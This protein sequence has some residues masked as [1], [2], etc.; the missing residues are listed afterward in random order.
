MIAAIDSGDWKVFTQDEL[1]P[2]AWAGFGETL[3]IF[4]NSL[5]R[6][7]GGLIMAYRVVTPDGRRRIATCRLREDWSV[8]SGS[9]QPFSDDLTY[10]DQNEADPASGSWV[11]DP[12]FVTLQGRLYLH[13]NF[14][15][16]PRPNRIYLVEVDPVTLT[17]VS[18]AR[19][20]V[21]TGSRQEIEKNWIFFEHGEAVYVVYNFAPLVILHADL[22]D[23]NRVRCTPAFRHEWDAACYEGAYGQIRGGATPVDVNGRFH[24]ICHSA[25]RTDPGSNAGAEPEDICYVA[26]LVVLDGTPPFAPFLHSSRPV[27]E[28]T[29]RE[30]AMPFQPRL[31]PRCCEAVYPVGAVADGADLIVSYGLNNRYAVLRRMPRSE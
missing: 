24:F 15:S 16:N 12:R 27:L 28:A 31:D 29:A 30:Q 19:E 3:S 20:V 22:T 9:V 10:F 6:H 14:G 13:F 4:N 25:F 5:Y 11:A 26:P 7:D 18:P 2:V 1:T 17:P 23:V 8:V 21:R